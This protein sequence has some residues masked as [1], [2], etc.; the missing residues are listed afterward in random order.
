MAEPD[1]QQT[2]QIDELAVLFAGYAPWP[3]PPMGTTISAASTVT[4]IRDGDRKIIMDPGFVP[5]RSAILDPL[6]E[7]GYAPE[8]VTDLIFSHHHPDHTMNAALFPNARTHDV[9]GVYK[10][11][12][13]LV[14]AAEG[15]EVSPSIRLI[16]TPGHTQ[17]DITALASTKDGLVAFTHLW[18]NDQIPTF[19]DP[20]ATDQEAF[21]VSRERVLAL[22]PA[23]IVP[24]HGPAF[25]PTSKTPR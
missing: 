23:L 10:D 6:R 20:V 13:W 21:H 18:W 24:G 2:Q 9:W 12:T 11:D 4:F 19:D 14:R 15:V 1:L 22:N 3:F 16:E 5:S 7:L 17:S 25:A 8:D